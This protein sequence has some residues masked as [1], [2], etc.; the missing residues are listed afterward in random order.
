MKSPH[1]LALAALLGLSGTV[2]AAWTRLPYS[3]SK[4][5]NLAAKGMPGTKIIASK[6]VDNA[7]NLFSPDPS[8]SAHVS[9]GKSEVTIQLVNQQVLELVSFVNDGVEGKVVCAGSVDQKNWTTLGRAVFSGNERMVQVSFASAQAKYVS[10]SIES[11]QGGTIRALHVYGNS[12][13]KDFALKPTASSGEVNLVGGVGGGRAIYAFPSPSSVGEMGARFN[14]FKFPNTGD[15]Y[16]IVVYDLGMPRTIREFSTAYSQHPVRLEVFAFQELPE[17]KDWR[18]KL[19]LDPAIFDQTRPIASGEDPRGVGHIKV[20]PAKPVVAQFVALRFEPNYQRAA[21]GANFE[22]SWGDLAQLT[23]G[24]A[25]PVLNAFH[26]LPQGQFAVADSGGFTV[27]DINVGSTGYSIVSGNG[28][29]NEGQGG[30]QPGN[31]GEV[32]DGAPPYLPG[33]PG[34]PPAGTGGL[35]GGGGSSGTSATLTT[36]SNVTVNVNGAASNNGTNAG[37]PG[38]NNPGTAEP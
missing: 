34:S 7:T 12:T 5:V 35:P 30:N 37:N 16:R 22:A 23:F 14:V 20:V 32:K 3:E 33:T 31:T 38:N 26:L 15:K 19:T 24:S 6:G 1:L 18:G 13:G 21:T 2:S 11:A 25:A 29:G 4:P 17:K 8:V 10:V 36:P 28:T 27:T 9:G